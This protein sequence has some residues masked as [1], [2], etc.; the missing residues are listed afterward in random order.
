MAFLDH[1]RALNNAGDLS[2]WLPFRVAGIDAGHVQPGFAD[3]LH[4]AGGAFRIAD[5]AVVIDPALGDFAA[6][7]AAAEAVLRRL[8]GAGHIRS[9]KDE[10]SPVV[11]RW[12]DDP[13]MTVDRAAAAY[14]GIR[15]FGV[16]VVGYVRKPDGLHLWI[17]RRSLDRATA[18]GKFDSIV[19]GGQPH[20]LTLMENVIKE[21]AEEAGMPAA[22]ARTA[23][24]S[25]IVSYV[26]RLPEGLR[27]DTLFQFDIALPEDF[28]PFCAD[29]ENEGYELWPAAEVAA[30]IRGGDAFKFNVNLVL[31]DFLIRHGVITPDNEPDYLPLVAGLRVLDRA[32]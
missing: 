13:P 31:I 12:D 15:A 1:I 20:G 16:H 19:A 10:P 3:L 22:L 2:G 21:S 17:A 18:P 6:R 29:G 28:L 8:H 30:R 25:G 7:T 23:T 32:A 24:P 5:G 11:A 26:H 27:R 14:L 9:W 4:G